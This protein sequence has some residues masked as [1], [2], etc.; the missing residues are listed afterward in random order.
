MRSGFLGFS[1]ALPPNGPV[2]F[3]EGFEFFGLLLSL[4][5]GRDES[6]AV[7]GW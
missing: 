7:H 4:C 3:D 2:G 5:K 1:G 6:V